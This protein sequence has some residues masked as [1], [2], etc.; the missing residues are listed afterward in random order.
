[1]GPLLDDASQLQ[2]AALAQPDPSAWLSEV[3][4]H[5]VSAAVLGT[6]SSLACAADGLRKAV[7][8]SDQE[9]LARLLRRAVEM[10]ALQVT[11]AAGAA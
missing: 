7:A 3:F 8:L 10:R 11:P 5:H 2:G 4:A 9:T 1:M 6:D